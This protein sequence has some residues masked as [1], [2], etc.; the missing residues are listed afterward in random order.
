M[1]YNKEERK[2]EIRLAVR[3]EINNLIP[4]LV[5]LLVI[6]VG[7]I[8]ITILTNK[9][10]D[11]PK[12]EIYGYEGSADPIIL[13]DDDSDLKFQMDPMTTF[14]TVTDK[15]TGKTWTS[16]PES[17][18]RD[19]LAMGV[20][21]KKLQSTLNI[22]YSDSGGGEMQYNN[23]QF[24]IENHTYDIIADKDKVKVKYSIGSIEREYMLPLLIS[25]TRF[26]ELTGKMNK[27]DGL[28]AEQFYKKY[29]INK[30]NPTDQ[31]N[32]DELLSKYPDMANE[33]IYV[34][35]DTTGEGIKA[36]YEKLFIEA[37]FTEEEYELS[38]EKYSGEKNQD[39]AVFNVSIVY[40]LDGNKLN[41][42]IPMEEIEY[43]KN[44]PLVS[45]QV[46]PFMGAGSW[47]EE[48]SVLIPEG[49]GS[50]IDFNNGKVQQSAYYSNVYGW[51]FAS[52]RKELVHETRANYPVFGVIKKDRS[53]ICSIENGASYASINADVA[54]KTNSFNNVFAE[55][56]TLHRE[57][58]DVAAKMKG[59]MFYYEQQI[60]KDTLKQSYI[61]IDSDKIIDMAKAYEDHLE[62]R[63]G[64]DFGICE[65]T[66]V[67]VAVEI[68]AAVDKIDQVAGVPVSKPLALT[69]YK[70]AADLIKKI[71]DVGVTD[72]SIKL[73]GW[74]NEGVQQEMLN[75]V[76]L[77]KR[78]GSKKDFDSLIKYTNDEK[79]KLYLDAVTQYEFQTNLFEGFYVYTDAACYANKMRVEL[80]DFST[81][82]FGPDDSRDSYYLLKPSIA[83]DMMRN[84]KDYASEKDAYGVSFRDAGYHLS[85][86][87]KRKALVTREESMNMQIDEMKSIKEDGL[88]LMVNS[89]ND[90][91]FGLADYIT[92]MDL[93]GF[94]YTIIDEEVP[95]LFLALHGHINYSG[96]ALNITSQFEKELLK[97]VEC[98]AGLSFVFMEEDSQTLQDT[99]YSEYFG[100]SYESWN[101]RFKEV[102]SRYSKELGHTFNQKISDWQRLSN[103]VTV[104]EYEDGTKAYV[105]YGYSDYTTSKGVKIPSRDYVVER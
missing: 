62:K 3:K 69:T 48:G 94:D 100:A 89:G 105:N 14:F 83:V 10:E 74:M 55:Y 5:V 30:L 19:P 25:A 59:R 20:D 103:Y 57:E 7:A 47:E 68:L 58:V 54:G 79:V 73:T 17:F 31:K 51:D 43:K 1:Y 33:V 40:S 32:K 49:G 46:L 75:K 27:N 87:F 8:L 91:V 4:V 84:I 67:P 35:R 96:E 15:K 13:E 11:P 44:Y 37:G 26:K 101:E 60:P 77:I 53:F 88:G 82:Y 52:G 71:K 12:I 98:G 99:T 78:L 64:D 36:K 22:R 70:E 45:I 23:Y 56:T 38:K 92:N 85:S 102:Y 9:D 65:N 16:I 86:D 72:L 28:G 18:D 50:L 24:S 81:I 21:K 2:K 63:L 76:K 41:V 34:I 61:F 39:D 104:T 80:T 29:D 90:Y 97:S 6:V 95:F 66:N 42:E 93:S